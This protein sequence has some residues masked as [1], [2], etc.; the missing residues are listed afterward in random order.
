MKTSNIV[1][2]ALML[3]VY[4]SVQA[5]ENKSS[6]ENKTQV[7]EI[8]VQP[9][10]YVGQSPTLTLDDYKMLAPGSSLLNQD[11]SGYNS[12]NNYGVTGSFALAMAVGITFKDKNG[13]TAKKNP[14]LRVGITYNSVSFDDL[15]YS[16]SESFAHDTLTSSQTGEM[17]FIDST[18]YSG[19]NMNHKYDQL[20]VDAS[21][22]FRTDPTAR[23]HLFGGVGATAG[24]SLISKTEISYYE[25]NSIDQINGN[26]DTYG[27]KFSKYHNDYYGDKDT[28]TFRNENVYGFSGYIP[29]G[30]DFR[31]SNKNEFFKNVHLYYEVRPKV[32]F[33][34]VPELRTNVTAGFQQGIGVKVTWL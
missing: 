30:V 3:S 5:Q 20:S 29:I 6:D 15:S 16:K 25:S 27:G 17:Y 33:N 31:I 14:V 18:V 4:G 19:Y 2:L 21:L 13:T 34:T 10:L 12:S 7:S 26:Y 24:I 9:G 22:L 1:V 32:S 28:E 23:W 11:L 8:Y